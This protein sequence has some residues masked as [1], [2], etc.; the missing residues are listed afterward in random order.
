MLKTYLKYLEDAGLIN[1]LSKSGNRLS[2]LEKPQKIYLNNSNQAYAFGKE[3][4]NT[5][6][7]RETFFFNTTKAGHDVSFPAQ[8][9]FN[10]N[11]VVFEVGGKSKTIDQIRNV[12]S[13]F[14]AV[15]GMEIGYENVVP[16]WLFGF[17]Y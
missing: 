7:V 4:T 15:D 14:L 8:G 1:M 11:G 12:Q 13:A 16:L 10:V 5:G 3:S 9:D 2:G 17:L 6:N